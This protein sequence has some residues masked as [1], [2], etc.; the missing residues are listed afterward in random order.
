M[1][2][3]GGRKIGNTAR[4]WAKHAT[5]K[6]CGWRASESAIWRSL[7]V[8]KSQIDSGAVA[9]IADLDGGEQGERALEAVDHPADGE[10]ADRDAEQEAEQ[11]QAEGVDARAEI[12]DEDARPEHLESQ[13]RRPHEH[14]REEQCGRLATARRRRA[15]KAAPLR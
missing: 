9:A 7:S 4:S 6:L 3:V 11:H 5:P 8:M 2:S 13:A 10:A 1:S 14:R 15:A 12:E